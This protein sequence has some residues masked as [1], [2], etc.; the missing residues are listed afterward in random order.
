MANSSLLMNHAD[1]PDNVVIQEFLGKDLGR[2]AGWLYWIT[3]CCCFAALSATVG[4][5]VASLWRVNGVFI[6]V[7][8]AAILTPVVINLMD[9]H[10][11]KQALL[12][13]A[14][15]KAAIVVALFF[16]MLWINPVVAHTHR[17]RAEKRETVF[18]YTGPG[19]VFG[20]LGVAIFALCSAY[21]GIESIAALAME[22]DVE[23]SD[24]PSGVVKDNDPPSLERGT[25]IPQTARTN[26][27]PDKDLFSRPAV[28]VPII[29]MVTY[30]ASGWIVTENIDWTDDRLPTLD[31]RTNASHSSFINSA[32]DRSEVL[33][34]VVTVF[35]IVIAASTAATTLYVASRALYGM[36]L[37][38]SGKTDGTS[39]IIN[40]VQNKVFSLLSSKSRF[41]VPWI[42]VLVSALIPSFFPFM[43][44]VWPGAS[45]PVCTLPTIWELAADMCRLSI[46][47]SSWAPLVAFL[48][49]AV[50]AWPIGVSLDGGLKLIR[51]RIP[52]FADCYLA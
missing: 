35:M 5:L 33:G 50:S 4:D 24:S 15:V 25:Q 11:L 46:V 28:L 45:G 27:L 10:Y 17:N 38:H 18:H 26:P 49:G 34:A 9:I 1:L 14:T 20:A 42:A 12:F 19:G 2:V 39:G 6:V 13:L 22:A 32:R 43:K 16:I 21:V 29:A 23:P 48:C 44:H 3:H 47:L 51:K 52:P 8:F 37:I 36:A 31:G 41:N 7:L 40:R 30:V